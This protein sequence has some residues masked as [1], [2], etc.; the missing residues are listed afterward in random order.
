MASRT[1]P[2]GCG[3][4][5]SMKN[6]KRCPKC[7]VM[8]Y[9]SPENRTTDHPNHEQDCN[10]IRY[11]RGCGLIEEIN[12]EEAIV[13]QLDESFKILGHCL[14]EEEGTK[15]GLPGQIPQMLLR[16]GKNEDC[17][18]FLWD[19]SHM[20]AFTLLK[21][22]LALNLQRMKECEAI[23]GRRVPTEILF[24]IQS[25]IPQTEIISGH[26][27]LLKSSA[28]RVIIRQLDVQ[29]EQLYQRIK[30]DTVVSG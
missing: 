26:A 29:I 13:A 3:F 5:G 30:K 9:C 2:S 22:R 11:S 21:I 24:M 17:Y 14:S 20:I 23:V 27:G 12:H 25:F 10:R 8:P 6:L 28:R 18:A 4:C 19:S 15:L 7:T 1:L 16:L